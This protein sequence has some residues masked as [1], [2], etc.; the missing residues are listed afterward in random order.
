MSA[1]RH[2]GVSRGISGRTLNDSAWKIAGESGHTLQKAFFSDV[3]RGSDGS[4]G[5]RGLC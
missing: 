4:R 3:T 1:G 2:S 5:L